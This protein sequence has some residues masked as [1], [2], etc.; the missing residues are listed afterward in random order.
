MVDAVG[1]LTVIAFVAV[2]WAV[3]R[4]L[5]RIPPGRVALECALIVYLIAVLYAVT[6]PLMQGLLHDWVRF[7]GFVNLVPFATVTE[8]L[9][10][11]SP[12]QAIRQIIGNV[13]MLIPLGV[14]LPVL[15]TRFRAVSRVAVAGLTVSVSI[16]AIQLGL[17][18]AKL[19]SHSID[20]DD[21]ILNT[22]GACLG[23]ALWLAAW[24]LSQE[25]P[26]QVK[27]EN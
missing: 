12:A 16:E 27:A 10:R 14:L 17:W 23:Y 6:M 20:V 21:L 8:L 15:W 7:R 22:V 11:E 24:R 4:L 25:S 26:L 1:V 3:I 19:G 5:F 2:P 9:R 13:V 18:F